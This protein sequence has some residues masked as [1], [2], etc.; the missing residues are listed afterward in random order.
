MENFT[1]QHTNRSNVKNFIEVNHYSKNINGIKSTFCFS[2]LDK[3]NK[4]IGACVFGQMS[5][6]A[7][8]KFSS[9]ESDVIELRRLCLIDSAPRNTESWFISKCIKYIKKNSNANVIVSYA[10][11]Y[12]NHIGYIYQASNFLF[13]GETPKDKVLLDEETMKTYHSRALRTK[14]NGKL[15]PFAQ[16][17]QDKQDAGKLKEIIV[18]GKYCYVFPLTKQKKEEF[19]RISKSYP[20]KGE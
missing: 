4:M 3:E 12:Y 13:I 19:M 17:L 10:D 5:T 9:K 20:K 11:P 8:K 2:L 1:F 15:K 16:R 14:Y 7:W 6:T 18:P